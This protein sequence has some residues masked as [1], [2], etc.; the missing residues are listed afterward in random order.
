MP[1]SVCGHAH[2]NT[3]TIPTVGTFPL[4]PED[5][6]VSREQGAQE[7]K[8]KIGTLVDTINSVRVRMTVTLY[9]VERSVYESIKTFA[10]T[11][12]Q[13]YLT[14]FAGSVNLDL[15]GESITGAVIKSVQPGGSVIND[16]TP[17]E[18]YLNTVE[19]EIF[20]NSFSW[21]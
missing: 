14:T 2:S 6:E 4:N 9:Y 13:T 10:N 15:G 21:I 17:E 5:V 1:D 20:A 16:T 12:I 19:L 3:L 7:I 18:E 11:D 8:V